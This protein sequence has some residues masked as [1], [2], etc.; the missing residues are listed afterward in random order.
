[1]TILTCLHWPWVLPVWPWPRGRVR[2]FPAVPWCAHSP[3]KLPLTPQ[4]GLLSG[5]L[6]ATN[7]KSSQANSKLRCYQV[8]VHF[9]AKVQNSPSLPYWIDVQFFCKH[10]L[11]TPFSQIF[12]HYAMEIQ[13]TQGFCPF[14]LANKVAT[15]ATQPIYNVFIV[16]YAIGMLPLSVISNFCLSISYLEVVTDSN[17]YSLWNNMQLSRYPWKLFKYFYHAWDIPYGTFHV[18]SECIGYP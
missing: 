18:F 13:G 3:V 10:P 5:Q 2:P 9:V 17:F 11:N 4:H 7:T 12:I 16:H 14:S 1:M 6:A 15:K 8:V